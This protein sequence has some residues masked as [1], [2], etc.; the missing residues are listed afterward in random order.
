MIE[1]IF[2]VVATR[3]RWRATRQWLINT[4]KLNSIDFRS[5]D[6]RFVTDVDVIRG[7][8]NP[9][10]YLVNNYWQR[11]DWSDIKQALAATHS[12]EQFIEITV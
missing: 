4:M 2:V 3:D 6:I 11:D 5:S 1:P 9:H 12:L 7:F 10:G 8:T